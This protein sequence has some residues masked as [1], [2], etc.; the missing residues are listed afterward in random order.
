MGF[1][2]SGGLECLQL[3]KF[4]VMGVVRLYLELDEQKIPPSMRPESY[5]PIIDVAPHNARE[6]KRRLTRQGYS[7]ITVPL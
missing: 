6:L 3:I 4:G 2:H 5:A 1:S 7:V